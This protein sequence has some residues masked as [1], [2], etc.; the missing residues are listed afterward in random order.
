MATNFGREI[1]CTT[2]LQ[3]GRFVSGV[4][5]VAQANFR[6]LITP[7]GMLRGGEDEQNYGLDLEELIG[8]TPTDAPSL[9]GRVQGELLKDERNLSVRVT[10]A[11]TSDGVAHSYDITIECDTAEGPFT[12]QIAA[13]DVSVEL[14]GIT[15]G[16]A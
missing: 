6:R 4:L 2:S 1:S 12:L 13:S 14:L 10:V 15:L 3:T 16:G 8:T 5:A 9:E 11:D 7:R